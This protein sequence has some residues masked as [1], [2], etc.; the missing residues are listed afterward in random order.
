[1]TQRSAVVAECWLLPSAESQ[2]FFCGFSFFLL[3]PPPSPHLFLL[4][5]RVSGCF[6]HPAGKR[7]RFPMEKGLPWRPAWALI[8]GAGEPI[9]RSSPSLLSVST[10]LTSP[11]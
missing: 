7:N 9:A 1:M 11:P 2:V 3:S 4:F 8:L 6:V 5:P 10:V